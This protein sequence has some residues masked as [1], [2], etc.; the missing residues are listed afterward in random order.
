MHVDGKPKCTQVGT[1]SSL[2]P[3]DAQCPH[4]KAEQ[5]PRKHPSHKQ[6]QTYNSRWDLHRTA[7]TGD[8][9]NGLAEWN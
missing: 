8:A 5:L 9:Q 1:V 4:L 6:V 3:C 2:Q 7:G